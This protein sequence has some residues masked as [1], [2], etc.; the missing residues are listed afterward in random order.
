MRQYPCP[1]SIPDYVSQERYEKEMAATAKVLDQ[2]EKE[3]AKM[4]PLYEDHPKLVEK[5]GQL[6]VAVHFTVDRCSLWTSITKRNVYLCVL[7]RLD[8]FGHSLGERSEKG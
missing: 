4:R 2:L 8:T 6:Q 7:R 3:N 1:L 5:N